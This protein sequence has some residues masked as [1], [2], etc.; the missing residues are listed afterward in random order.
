[1][2]SQRLNVC[3]Y[4]V[5]VY[6]LRPLQHFDLVDAHL[7]EDL[8]LFSLNDLMAVRSGELAPKLRDL[9][10]LGSE[11]VASCV[12]RQLEYSHTPLRIP[13]TV[14]SCQLCRALIRGIE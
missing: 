8:H 11:H 6:V 4:C 12:V 7:T 13:L 3:N 2:F 5:C 14:E 1:M 10:R 9:V